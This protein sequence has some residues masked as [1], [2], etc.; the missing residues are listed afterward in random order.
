MVPPA[1]F[2][3]VAHG[4]ESCSETKTTKNKK[5]KEEGRDNKN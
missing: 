1:G 5:E 3:P 4:L 2:E